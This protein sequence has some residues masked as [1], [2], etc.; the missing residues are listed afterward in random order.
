MR[1]SANASQK[2]AQVLHPDVEAH[3]SIEGAPALHGR[4]AIRDWMTKATAPELRPLDYH[5]C[6]EHVIVR[7]YIRYHEGRMMTE[8]LAFWLFELEDGMVR[9][10]ASYPTREAALAEV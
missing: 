9:R 6:G 8:R 4:D 1:G 3:P 10:M 7:G 2:P 5:L